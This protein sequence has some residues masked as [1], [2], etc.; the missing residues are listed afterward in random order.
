M[1][2]I[3]NPLYA[4]YNTAPPCITSDALGEC[5]PYSYPQITGSDGTNTFVG[6]DVWAPKPGWAQTMYSMNPGSWHV[7]ANM[8]AGNTAV[9]S[10][11][12]TGQYYHE[13]PLASF[14]SL[15]SSFSENLNVN[16]NPGSVGEAAYDM[17]FNAY[18]DEVMIQHD[19]LGDTLRPRCDAYEGLVQ[20]T[21][22]FGGSHGVPVQAWNLCVFGAEK[23]WQLAT[24]T[25]IS[26]S[27]VDILAMV[28]W[29]EQHGY[30][31]TTN[32]TIT[33]IGYGFEICSTGGLNQTW[34]VT[35]YSITDTRIISGTASM[36]ST[37]SL[38]TAHEGTNYR[39]W[40]NTDGP[41]TAV[42]Y[43]GNL[44]TGVEFEVTHSADWFEGYWLWVC[45]SGQPTTPVEC[46]LWSMTGGATGTLVASSVV[47]SGT[48]TAGQWNYIP[49]SAPIQLALG[50]PYTAAI[51]VNGPFPDTPNSFGAGDPYSAGIV[52]G[53]LTGYSDSSGSLPPPYGNGQ[54]C[55][56]AAGSDPSVYMPVAHGPDNFWVD[57]QI[58]DGIP[59][60]FSYSGSWRLWPNMWGAL[61]ASTD[62]PVN[63]V[64]ATEVHFSRTVTLNKIWYYSIAGTAQLATECGV[65]SIA[66]QTLVADNESPTWSGAAGSGWV[67]CSFTSV[68]IPAGAYRVAVYNNAATPD[69]WSAKLLNYWDIGLGSNGITTGGPLLAPNLAGASLANKFGES[70]QEPGQ[71][72][73][74]VGPPDQ[75]P[76]LYVDGLAQ[77]YWVDVEVT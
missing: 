23:I 13:A 49:L 11:P 62:S 65:W 22:S 64:I 19:F 16:P 30:M 67:S 74:A 53:P 72:V 24:G 55:A 3:P 43:S 46:A 70:G 38:A 40:P 44:I 69:A 73:F 57:V 10:F 29:L 35:G 61:G 51:G 18:A 39:L 4:G 77:N 75:Y 14:S 9:I 28:Q 58:S 71:A 6:N 56:T 54:G 52:T 42:A 31:T 32:S 15:Y 12:N 17:W 41:A 20:A 47:T 45:G 7:I 59:P 2:A 27:S 33:A 25:N 66:T 63:Y 26:S 50:A 37:A 36:Y 60:G 1:R 34:E 5:G 8:P 48:L 21:V 76:N 68:T